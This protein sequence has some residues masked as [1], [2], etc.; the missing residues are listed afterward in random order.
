MDLFRAALT[1]NKN[2]TASDSSSSSSFF[3]ATAAPPPPPLYPP[4]PNQYMYKKDR[5]HAVELTSSASTMPLIWLV[6]RITATT[7]IDNDD[8]SA[9]DQQDYG[10]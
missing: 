9:L 1:T 10:P 2:T 8:S 3:L 5:P 7:T 6:Q 4:V